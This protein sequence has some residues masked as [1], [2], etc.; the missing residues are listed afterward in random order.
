VALNRL[1]MTYLVGR[2]GW[3]T[4]PATG[5]FNGAPVLVTRNEYARQLFNGDVGIALMDPR[6][7]LRLYVQRGNNL[8]STPIQA[9]GDWEPAFATTVHKSQGS[10]YTDVLLV[11]PGDPQHRLLSREIVYTGITRARKRLLMVAQPEEVQT[12]LGHRI[13]RTTGL[14]WSGP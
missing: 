8:I 14:M 9:L 5:L 11:F 12:A 10:E 2:Y 6:G 13:Q 1:M 3:R 4:D 7:S